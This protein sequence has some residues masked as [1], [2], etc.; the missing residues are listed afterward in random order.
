MTDQLQHDASH[1]KAGQE[2]IWA[3]YQNAGAKAFEA[4]EPQLDFFGAA[5]C[6]GCGE[7]AAGGAERCWRFRAFTG[8]PSGGDVFDAGILRAA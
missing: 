7:D 8:L 4:A 3:H 1:R 5:D 2:K 6:A